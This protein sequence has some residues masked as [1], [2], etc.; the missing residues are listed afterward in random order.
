[1]GDEVSEVLRRR[2]CRSD[3]VRVRNGK[4]IVPCGMKMMSMFNDTFDFEGLP[5]DTG[6]DVG[7]ASDL[8]RYR[9]PP[10]F[11]VGD[12]SKAWLPDIFPGIVNRTLGVKDPRFVEWMRPGATPDLKKRYGWIHRTLAQGET[13]RLRVGNNFDVASFGGYKHLVLT[14]LRTFGGRND[15]LGCALLGGGLFSVPPVGA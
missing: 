2:F 9:N 13:L 8:D 1:M 4:D 5:V 12:A 14:E 10:G 6:K 11:V 3:H 7:W 15:G